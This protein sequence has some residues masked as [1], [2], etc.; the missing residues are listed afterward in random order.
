MKNRT[1]DIKYF[2]ET[3]EIITK[4][5]SARKINEIKKYS[6][7]NWN[8]ISTFNYDGFSIEFIIDENNNEIKGEQIKVWNTPND[9]TLNRIYLLT[10]AEKNLKEVC[11]IY[12]DNTNETVIFLENGVNIH[13]NSGKLSLITSKSESTRKLV[14][15]TMIQKT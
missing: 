9:L 4:K 11:A 7:E 14:S 13:Y 1:I 3:G 10:N 15:E 8:D 12:S 5:K 2:L 6:N